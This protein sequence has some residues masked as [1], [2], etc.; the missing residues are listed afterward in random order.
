MKVRIILPSCYDETRQIL[1]VNRV[2]FPNLTTLHLAA[3]VPHQHAVSVVDE[4]LQEIPFDDPVDLVGISVNTPNATRAYAVADEYRKRGVRVI[5]GGIH[6]SFLP[7]EAAQHA[8]AVVV[9]EAEDAWPAALRDAESGNL[10]PRYQC[11]PRDSLAGLPHPRFDLLDSA[12]Y[13][14]LPFCN[15]AMIPIQTSRGCP[16]SCDF[17]SVT[18]FWGRKLRFRP[19]AEIVEEVKLS[20]GDTFFFTDDNF[21]A[22]HDRARELLDALTP[23]RIK[24]F[25]QLDTTVSRQPEMV[26]RLARS[27]CMLA[28]I[29]IESLRPESLSQMKKG[30]NKPQEYEHLFSLFRK[31]GIT[32]YASIIVGAEGDNINSVDDTVR[33]LVQHK[34]GIAAFFPLTPFPGTTLYESL[35]AQGRLL[36]DQWW[37]SDDYATRFMRIRYESETDS[38]VRL[39]QRAMDGFY[40]WPAVARRFTPPRKGTLL[41]FLINI[42]IKKR[43]RKSVAGFL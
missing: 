27:G 9:G 38:N 15:S 30:F 10:Q 13:V 7:E 26:E 1:K 24:Y 20:G 21:I 42:E 4:S 19:V 36:H 12:K 39:R 43:L 23:L 18:K 40:A 3:L 11:P 6:A 5:M 31:S 29:G 35:R 2:V 17:C 14:H 34:A 37:L 41:P 25:C 33:F 8:D 32:I 16:H 22:N 28:F